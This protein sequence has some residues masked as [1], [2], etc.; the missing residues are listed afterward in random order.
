LRTKLHNLEIKDPFIKGTRI[1]GFQ[2]TFS[3]MQLH[4]RK[5]FH[6]NKGCMCQNSKYKD[7]NGNF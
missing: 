1:K 2:S 3:G 4:E 6:V 7:Y 5:G